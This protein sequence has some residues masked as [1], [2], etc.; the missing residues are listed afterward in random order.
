MEVSMKI[1]QLRSGDENTLNFRVTIIQGTEIVNSEDIL[2][3]QLSE[4]YP[5]KKGI[6]KIGRLSYNVWEVKTSK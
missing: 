5:L 3:N 6:L 2:L 1:N 4:T